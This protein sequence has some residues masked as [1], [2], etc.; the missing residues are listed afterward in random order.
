MSTNSPD[1]LMGD[2][3]SMPASPLLADDAVVPESPLPTLLDFNPA[4]R[5]MENLDALR[6]LAML[7]IIVTHI[8][9]PFVDD[10]HEHAPYNATYQAVFSLNV[11]LR[12]GVPC[13]LMISFFIYWHQLYE[14][15]RT[16]GELL[17]RRLRRLVP[18]FVCWSLFYFAMHKVLASRGL[19]VDPGPLGDHLNWKSLDVWKQVF[20]LG[21]AHEHLY[22][23]PVVISALLLIPLL[24]VLWRSPAVAWAWVGLTLV[25]WSF[26]AYG[27]AYLPAGSSAY[28]FAERSLLVSQN[29][30]A[31][32]LLVFPLVGMMCAGQISWRRFIA[33]TPTS[34]WVGILI[35]GIALHILETLAILP[36]QWLL[37]LA[38]PKVGRFLTAVPVF[39]LFLRSPLMK[40]PFPR[41]SHHA[42]G[43]HFMHPAI[44]IGL[45]IVEGYLLRIGPHGLWPETMSWHPLALTGL[46]V[47]NF[48]LTFWITFGLCLLVGRSKRLEFLV[49]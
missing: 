19:N 1:P 29:F 6:I 45:T 4:T 24:R 37:A 32:P 20:L 48:I 33:R 14:K 46:L 35:V 40:D 23:L 38:W 12:F 9:Q 49:V 13:F 47:V 39:V 42:F 18:A 2:P 30:L 43:L 17:V 11:A 8:T 7:V 25:G 44:I 22:Y 41:V 21:R 15:G 26:V 34:L 3:K 31:L 28:R 5:H 36:R 10:G 16:W 27:M